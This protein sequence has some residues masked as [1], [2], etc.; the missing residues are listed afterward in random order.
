MKHLLP[1]YKNRYPKGHVDMR[2]GSLDVFDA[3]GEHRVALRVDGSGS[4]KCVSEEL[5]L[6]DRHCQAPIPKDARL[7]KMSKEGKLVK[8]EL[9]E[10]RAKGLGEF[11]CEDDLKVL[12]CE[13]LKAS[14]MEFCPKTQVL[15]NK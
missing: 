9:Y 6:P 1:M 14:G 13:E 12:S 3:K 7:Y 2:E 10:S 4:L 11:L 15:L 5:G 8:D